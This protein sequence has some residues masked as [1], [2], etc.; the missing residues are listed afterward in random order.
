MKQIIFTALTLLVFVAI[1][2]NAF[3][4]KI[5]DG[6]CP[7][8][9]GTCLHT[10]DGK[11]YMHIELSLAPFYESLFLNDDWYVEFITEDETKTISKNRFK[12]FNVSNGY[13]GGYECNDF[14]FRIFPKGASNSNSITLNVR[15]SDGFLWTTFYASFVICENVG[16]R[17]PES[18]TPSY[19]TANQD[20]NYDKFSNL[21]ITMA[22]NFKIYPNPIVSDFT[23]EYPVNQNEAVTFQIF[24]IEGRSI[25]ATELKHQN[26]GFYAEHFNSLPLTKGVYFCKIQ[27]GNSQK[28]L[29]VTKL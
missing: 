10:Y 19:K 22:N 20:S 29:R 15:A 9:D 26:T 2:Q 12:R 28:S 7:D 18:T 6:N 24:D 25:Y 1:N 17:P 14:R 8:Y 16:P 5:V 21:N 27:S 13:F 11:T 4:Q 23:I 3:C